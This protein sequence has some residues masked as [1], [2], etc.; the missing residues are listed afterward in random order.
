M[1]IALSNIVENKLT[2]QQIYIVIDPNLSL[3]IK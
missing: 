2:Y 1:A 3:I